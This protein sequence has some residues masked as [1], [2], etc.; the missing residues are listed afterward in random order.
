MEGS[1]RTCDEW[2]ARHGGTTKL[3]YDVRRCIAKKLASGQIYK[4][5]LDQQDG[6]RG[7]S[8]EEIDAL[9]EAVAKDMLWSIYHVS[10]HPDLTPSDCRV[11]IA[12]WFLS[13]QFPGLAGD[14]EMVQIRRKDIATACHLSENTTGDIRAHTA[15]VGL[16]TREPRRRK[17]GHIDLYVGAPSRVILTTEP[18][19]RSSRR[20][21]DVAR[22]Q[23]THCKQS[24]YVTQKWC[25]GTWHGIGLA[26]T[27]TDGAGCSPGPTLESAVGQADYEN[28][29]EVLTGVGGEGGPSTDSG[30]GLGGEMDTETPFGATGDADEDAVAS[31][32]LGEP[33]RT[34]V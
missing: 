33:L 2:R 27:S 28:R 12:T 22:K 29:A 9:P 34:C 7:W 8:R 30:V 19:A 26:A 4:E 11:A 23:C 3:R 14:Q 21:A 24:C 18:I 31:S 13:R 10:M 17:D 5:Q 16:L 1:A 15:D 20:K 32:S 25:R 6:A